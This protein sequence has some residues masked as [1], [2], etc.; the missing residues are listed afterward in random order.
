MIEHNECRVRTPEGVVFSL[1]PAGLPSRMIAFI[2]D[3]LMAGAISSVVSVAVSMLMLAFGIM[4][5]FAG[6]VI[7]GFLI[8]FMYWIASEWWWNGRTVG[9]KLL[10]LR[11]VDSGGLRLL[12]RQVIIR[13]LLRS[14]DFLPLSYMLGAGCAFID[15]RGRR[16]GDIAAG[17]MVIREIVPGTPDLSSVLPDKYN[18]L[19]DYPLECA[20]LRDA[21]SAD[22]SRMLLDALVRRDTLSPDARCDIYA[23]LAALIHRKVQFPQAAVDG[24]PDENFLRNVVDILY[25]T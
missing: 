23:D 11:V 3:V 6:K 17:T 19:R 12:P 1:Y 21:V 7:V 15:P 4:A 25:K 13:N 20:R 18:S 16:L 24:V 10:R 22:E 8:G 14:V 5:A 2:I 9:K